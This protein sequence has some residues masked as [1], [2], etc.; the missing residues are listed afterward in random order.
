MQ[1]G[2]TQALLRCAVDV[3]TPAM[4]DDARARI[5]ATYE[6]KWSG[7]R[8]AIEEQIAAGERDLSR[9]VHRSFASMVGRMPAR[10]TPRILFGRE[11]P[12]PYLTA[13]RITREWIADTVAE[14]ARRID[15]DAIVEAGSGWGHNLFLTWLRGGPDVAYHAFEYT[16][17]GRETTLRL[18]QAAAVGPCIEAHPFDY[19]TPDFSVIAGRVR[20][21]LVFT[22][23]SIEQIGTLPQGFIDEL[24]RLAP[25]VTVLHFEPVGWQ[26]APDD[27]FGLE[28]K[29]H[30]LRK[31]YNENLWSLL[32]ANAAAG[33]LTIDETMAN[34]MAPKPINSTSLIRWSK[35]KPA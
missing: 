30:C 14:H 23:H 33:S 34:V 25:Q 4:T 29:A 10:D 26:F 27:P 31:G 1:S 18:G 7:D 22:S 17:A 35:T 6:S 8:A 19:Y 28:V 3:L 13:F 16:E 32:N 11:A 21:P 12:A 24:L 9:I 2:G 15:A 5:K 20:R